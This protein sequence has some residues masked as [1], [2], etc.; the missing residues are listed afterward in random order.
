MSDRT[1]NP[2]FTPDFVSYHISKDGKH[3]LRTQQNVMGF[4]LPAD[5]EETLAAK[6]PASEGY[7]LSREVKRNGSTST[8]IPN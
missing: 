8:K 4:D 5:L 3:Y 6:F 7:V 1:E 2:N